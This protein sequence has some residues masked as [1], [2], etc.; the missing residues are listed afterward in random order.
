[1]RGFEF[2]LRKAETRSALKPQS[3]PQK[4]ALQWQKPKEHEPRPKHSFGQPLMR[5]VTW[6]EARHLRQG[7]MTNILNRAATEESRLL[8][9][10]ER[11]PAANDMRH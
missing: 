4:P 1:M 2:A 11:N 9:A 3:R 10:S 6:F 8:S 7:E 5:G